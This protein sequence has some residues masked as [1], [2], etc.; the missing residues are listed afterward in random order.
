[1]CM[2]DDGEGWEFYSERFS[3]ARKPHTCN[4]CTRTIHTGEVYRAAV[5]KSDGWMMSYATCTHC[6]VAC[7]WLNTACH[8]YLFDGVLIDLEE[9]EQESPLY[10]SNTLSALIE[11][12]RRGWDDGL[13][14]LPDVDEVRA[15]VPKPAVLTAG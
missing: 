10:R 13:A 15:S 4:E 5:G 3:E 9:H 12:M 7:E 11:G 8:G 14:P 1:M 6:L 2:V